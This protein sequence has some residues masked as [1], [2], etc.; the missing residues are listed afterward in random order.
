MEGSLVAYK[1]FTNGSVLNAS[2]I[3]DNLMRQSV[4]VFSNAAARTAAITSPVEGMLTWLEDVNRYESY[5]GSAWV[6]PFGMTLVGNSTFTAQT[7]IIFDNIFSSQFDNYKI[8]ASVSGSATSGVNWQLRV[9][10]SSLTSTTYS[11]VVVNGYSSATSSQIAAQS[12]GD[13]GLVRNSTKRNI[14]EA[15]LTNPFN[16][17]DTQAYSSVYDSV[18][19]G[20]AIAAFQNT[21]LASYDGIRIFAASGNFTG[22]IQIYGLRK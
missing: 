21:T 7:Q 20:I 12:N 8:Y 1:V 9:G 16:T 22:S 15:T 10:G 6:S 17:V 4:M 2:E 11:G 14:F 19:N 18:S 3:N 13:F 5:N